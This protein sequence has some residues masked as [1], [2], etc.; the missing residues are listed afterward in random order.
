MTPASDYLLTLAHKIAQPYTK[1][2]AIRAAMVTGSAAK[3]IADYHSDVD[4]TMYYADELPSEEVLAAIR[5]AHGAPERKWAMGDRAS[6]SFAEAY[7]V[8][9]I[10]VQIGHTTIA[11]WEATMAEVLEKLTCDTPI[12]KALEGT[13]NCIALHGADYLDRWQEQIRAYPPE[14]AAAMVKKHLAFFP[15]WGLEVHFKTR[16]ATI[17]Y[18][19]IMVEAAQNLLGVLAGLNQLYFATFQFKRTGRFVAEMA[20]A[21]PNLAQRIETIFQSD[22]PRALRELEMLVAETIALVEQYMPDIDTAHAQRRIGWRHEP[23]VPHEL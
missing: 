23:W 1:L 3:G 11:V 21:P 5:E 8:D 6:N 15:V 14:L 10:E 12:Q 9:G 22:M 7:E 4:M 18:Y 17:W 13:L 19:Q 16:D 2:P 20:I